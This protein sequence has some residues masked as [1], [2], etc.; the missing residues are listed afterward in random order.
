M[1]YLD[2]DFTD[3]QARRLALSGGIV[4]FK[5]TTFES[6]L[7]F[8]SWLSTSWHSAFLL[9]PSESLST[10]VRGRTSG[11]S[12]QERTLFILCTELGSSRWVRRLSSLRKRTAAWRLATWARRD[13]FSRAA[14]NRAAFSSDT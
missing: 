2:V 8:R 14:Q 9:P 12:S 4:C 13:S 3:L 1:W 11:A 5:S 6:I 10:E 7:S